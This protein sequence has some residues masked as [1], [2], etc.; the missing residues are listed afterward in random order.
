[1]PAWWDRRSKNSRAQIRFGEGPIA[2]LDAFP[3]LAASR[4]RSHAL[5]KELA[6]VCVA[7]REMLAPVACIAAAGSLGRLE[8]GDGSDLDAIVILRESVAP[9][10]V[11]V[12]LDKLWQAAAG[13]GLRIPKAEGIY[14]DGVT[15]AAL[16]D[17]DALGSLDE[18]PGVFGKRMQLLLDARPLFGMHDFQ[19][20]R[21]SV[22]AW[23]MSPRAG[24]GARDPW[25]YLVN[26]LVRYACAY[27]NWQ[28]AKFN[29]SDTDSWALR[30]VKLR[31]TRFVTWLGLWLLVWDARESN[32]DAVT[33]V[34]ERLALTPLERIV[35]V[36]GADFSAPL[37]EFVALYEAVIARLFD[38]EVRAR[39]V[40]SNRPV[41][42]MPDDDY[43]E[44]MG[45]CDAMR[46]VI[47]A[48]L[49]ARFCRRRS[50]QHP[51]LLPF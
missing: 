51:V 17:R 10:A 45:Q 5:L 50:R 25:E 1:M 7:D 48:I 42:V 4:Q 20:L 31:S 32:G 38:A 46:D 12:A 15:P 19:Q 37:R 21:E 47:D 2:F 6:S 16:V 30:Q 40:A 11:A 41:V 29:R 36:L 9:E 44:L 28:R 39:L 26:D 49:A 33:Q 43:D 13:V 34:R 18:P 14:R 24:L 3:L 22:F 8:A 35:L 27:T 23:Y